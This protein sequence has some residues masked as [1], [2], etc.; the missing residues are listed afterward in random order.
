MSGYIL[1]GPSWY[2]ASAHLDPQLAVNLIS[3]KYA[4]HLKLDFEE[5]RNTSTRPMRIS[6]LV[7]ENMETRLISG[8]LYNC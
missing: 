2:L 5:M 3:R 4:K 7:G 1:A 6:C 8:N